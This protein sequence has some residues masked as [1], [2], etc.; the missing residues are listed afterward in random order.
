[1]KH[2][3][4]EIYLTTKRM[5]IRDHRMED[6]P[7]H[8]AMISDPEVMYYLPDI[9]T[10]SLEESRSNLEKAVAAVGRPGRKEYFLRLGDK[11]TGE[12]IGEAGYT[13]LEETP[14]GRLVH[15]GYFSLKKFW[16]KGYMEE[17][18]REVLRFAFEENGVYRLTTGCDPENIGSERVMIKCG[19]TKEADMKRKVWFDGRMHDR[20][21]YRMLREEW[22]QSRGIARN[23]APQL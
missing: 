8:H 13:V 23:D 17:A 10:H 2:M 9:M 18:F 22:E 16:G 5:V 1:M 15:A 4:E 3:K 7:E 14:V 20:V 6:L 12:L 21:E 11:E 19:M